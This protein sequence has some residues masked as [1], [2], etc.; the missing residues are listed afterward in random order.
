MAHSPFKN[1]RRCH[2]ARAHPGPVDGSNVR[3]ALATLAPEILYTAIRLETCMCRL[4]K[5]TCDGCGRDLL[6][7]HTIVILTTEPEAYYTLCFECG[8]AAADELGWTDLADPDA[9]PAYGG[10]FHPSRR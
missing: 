1:L 6:P 4:P 5:G 2:R 10:G 8:R 9:P 3:P 7:G